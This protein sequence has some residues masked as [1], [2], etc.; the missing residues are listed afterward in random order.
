MLSTYDP[1]YNL[2]Q[3]TVIPCTPS[4]PDDTDGDHIFSKDVFVDYNSQAICE[5]PISTKNLAGN[6]PGVKAV[7][8][9][10]LRKLMPSLLC[11]L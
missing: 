10:H 2:Y 11:L 5:D 6:V 9:H 4:A 3:E 8:H 1:K 7:E